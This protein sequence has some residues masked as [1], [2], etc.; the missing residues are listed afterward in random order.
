MRAGILKEKFDVYVNKETTTEFGN[1]QSNWEKLYSVRCA[2]KNNGG[3]RT[4]ENNEIVYPYVKE[5]IVRHYVVI[6]E[7]MQI[8][9]NGKNYRVISIEPNKYY[10]DKIIV[11]EQINE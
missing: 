2:V 3:G 7:R 11:A 10:N 9:F 5:F 8:K 1:K 6:D 4:I